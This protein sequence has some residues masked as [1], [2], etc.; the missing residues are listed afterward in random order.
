MIQEALS[1]SY[2]VALARVARLAFFTGEI[3]QGERMLREAEVFAEG[4]AAP[5]TVAAQVDLAHSIHALVKG[6]LSKN[7]RLAESARERFELAGDRRNACQQ[8][9]NVG[10]A[11]LQLG[12]H[13]AAERAFRG[14]LAESDRLGIDA[15]ATTVKLNL[16]IALAMQSRLAEGIALTG[17][18]PPRRPRARGPPGRVLRPHLPRSVRAPFGDAERAFAEATAVVSEPATFP[19][20]RAFSKARN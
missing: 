17:G 18:G 6:D 9:S 11:Y 5:P 13:D 19:S 10:Y 1:A 14:A 20:L 2:A 3:A 4:G 8:V 16:G 7:L 12:V 15:L